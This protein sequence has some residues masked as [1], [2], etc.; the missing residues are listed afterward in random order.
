[1]LFP[2]KVKF[3]K[4]HTFRR[5]PARLSPETRGTEVSFGSFGLKS[6][7]YARI[8]SQQ[9]ESARKAMSHHMGKSG[10]MWIRMFPDKSYTQKPAE[11]KMGKGKGDL[12]GYECIIRA[13]K[14]LFEIDGVEEAVAREALRKAGTKLPVKTRVVARR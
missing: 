2:K 8:R 9:I 7:G 13:G 3:R 5:N 12:V 10:K 11:V 1:M 6:V 4:Q 14:V